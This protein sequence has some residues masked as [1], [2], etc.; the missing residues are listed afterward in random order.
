M[1]DS[2]KSKSSAGQFFKKTIF[3]LLN[4]LINYGVLKSYDR[5]MKLSHEGFSE[6]Q[7]LANFILETW[8][9]KF[10][11]VN[12]S[13]SFRSDR[14]KGFFYD[15][16]GIMENWSERDRV[17]AYISVFPNE[18][19]ENG[20]FVLA[21]ERFRNQETYLPITHFLTVSE[22]ESYLLEYSK[23]AETEIQD[24]VDAEVEVYDGSYYGRSGNQFERDLV[25]E[26][27]SIDNLIAYGKNSLPNDSIYS[28]ILDRIIHDHG[29]SRDRI[30]RIDATNKI[31]QLLSGGNPKADVKIDIEIGY[32]N[33]ISE[34]I[35][36]KKTKEKQVSCHDYSFERFASVLD[37]VDQ[38]LEKYFQ[39]FQTNPTYSRFEEQLEQS[40][41]EYSLV[42]FKELMRKVATKFTEW[43][44]TGAHD[45]ENILF[46]HDQISSYILFRTPN[47]TIFHPMKEYI[48]ML[49]QQLDVSNKYRYEVPFNWTYPSK[50]EGKRIQLKVPVLE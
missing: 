33:W 37:C 3:Q 39:L 28:I 5:Q 9:E 44:L 24:E 1:S 19:L 21:R 8:D 11:I 35:S 22:F 42:E 43:V 32:D 41:G 13:N 29:I 17:I 36:L 38:K 7:Y 16:A 27:R 46:P 23:T 10:M 31:P 20:S 15:F 45:K 12:T 47:K 50:Q 6:P 4:E 2:N 30:T 14:I 48:E 18:E 49:M 40:D 25:S 26:L 34:T